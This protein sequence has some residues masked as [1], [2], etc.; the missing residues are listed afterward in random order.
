MCV[1]QAVHCTGYMAMYRGCWQTH[2]SLGHLSLRGLRGCQLISQLYTGLHT[3][4]TKC[5]LDLEGSRPQAKP[6]TEQ[7]HSKTPGVEVAAAI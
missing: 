6:P 1:L 5:A 7:N 2:A 4:M 3:L